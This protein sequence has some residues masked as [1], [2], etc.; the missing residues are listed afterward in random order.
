MPTASTRSS[1]ASSS[2]SRAAHL[3]RN[4]MSRSGSTDERE[5]HRRMRVEGRARPSRNG[6]RG[7]TGLPSWG[8][9]L[10]WPAV[11]APGEIL[12]GYRID[13][14][15]G[16]GGMGIVY[17]A[18]HPS[19]GRVVVKVLRKELAAENEFIERMHREAR[20]AAALQHPNIVAAYDFVVG[21][22]AT[23]IVME[24]LT[25]ETLGARLGRE[26]RL[27]PVAAARIGIGTLSALAAAHA[28]GLVHRDVKP[29]NIFLVK[30][31][32]GR[33][34]VKL[35]DFGLVKGLADEPRLTT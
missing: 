7:R 25:G 24:R 33:D 5:G 11:L 4:P 21:P 32:G 20:S 2:T 34:I 30:G 14:V 23:F 15:L 6:V 10:G 12:G 3:R 1:K 31:P 27:S 16:V 17:G 22:T 19:R 18:T 28:E 29:D 26:Q 9:L 35:L 13:E 8:R